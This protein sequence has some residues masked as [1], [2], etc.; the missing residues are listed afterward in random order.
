MRRVVELAL[1]AEGGR[2]DTLFVDS[3][4]VRLGDRNGD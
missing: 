3:E 4:R 1:D 2:S